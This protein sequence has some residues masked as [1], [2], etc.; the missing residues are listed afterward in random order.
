MNWIHRARRA[1][2]KLADRPDEW[3]CELTLQETDVVPTNRAAPKSSPAA[4]SEMVLPREPIAS[5][6]VDAAGRQ[7]PAGSSAAISTVPLQAASKR[8]LPARVSDQGFLPI[9]TRKYVMLL[10]WTGRELRRDKRGAI[11]EDLAPILDRLGVDRSNWVDTVR[12]F[13][14]MFKQ[15]AGRASSLVQRCTALLTAL[16]SGQGGRASRVSVSKR[17]AR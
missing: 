3:L 16:V 6:H 2:P 8:P 5:D 13:G 17:L 12:D 11:P 4:P 9:E 15:A 14:R 7:A 1:R 10:D